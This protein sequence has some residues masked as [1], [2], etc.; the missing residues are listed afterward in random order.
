V[1]RALT[2][3][4]ALGL[5]ACSR[6][7]AHN[8]ATPSPT[9]STAPTIAVTAATGS[10]ALP[11][12]ELAGIATARG[13]WKIQASGDGDQAVFGIDGHP[14][15]FALRC[16]AGTRQIVFTRAASGAPKTMQIVATDG[17]ATFPAEPAGT[18]RVR[19]SDF[20][21]DTFLTQVLATASGRIGVKLD[22]GPTLAMP[23]DPV[24]G[25]TIKR[26]AAPRG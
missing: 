4:L 6:Q 14:S 10:A 24:I 15:L 22:D 17:A 19:A 3:A 13:S 20:V 26:C 8:Q 2:A 25:Q 23:A 12:P 9:P 1:R 5:A 18:G 21:T 16:D 11:A 7:P